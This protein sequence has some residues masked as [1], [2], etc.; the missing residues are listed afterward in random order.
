MISFYSDGSV[1]DTDI[2][3]TRTFFETEFLKRIQPEQIGFQFLD[4]R[5]DGL[6]ASKGATDF[7]MLFSSLSIFIILAVAWLVEM[8]F[9]IGVEQ[10]SREIGILQAVG[11][12][13]ARIRRRFLL[14]GGIIAGIGSLLGCLLA[15]GYAQ[16][17]IFGLHTWW[18]PAIGTPFIE[19][20]AS[21][22]S[23]LMV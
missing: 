13:L 11:Y 12:P 2:H 8:F 1:P 7:G 19:F 9:R 18:L 14:E 22:W 3:A 17:M 15:V 16:L 20:H 23:L 4:L 5:A 6:Q 10:R 21:L